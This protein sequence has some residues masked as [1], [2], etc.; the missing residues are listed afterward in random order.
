M[1]SQVSRS[2]ASGN[3]CHDTQFAEAAAAV[4]AQGAR[5]LL[6]PAQ[7]MMRRDE[8]YIGYGPTSFL[9]PQAGIEAQVPLMTTGLVI[10]DIG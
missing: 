10:A 7:N 2:R 6:V 8:R 5:L 4:A 3:I 1:T 9:N